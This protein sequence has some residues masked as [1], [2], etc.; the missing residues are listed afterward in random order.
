MDKKIIATGRNND[1][2]TFALFLSTRGADA[3]TA[4][5][6][7]RGELADRQD[8]FTRD[9]L[10]WAQLQSGDLEGARENIALALAEGTEDARLFYHAG[11]IAAAAQ[12]NL[13]ALAFSKK[14]EAI[15]QMLLPSERAA[16]D[17][18]VAAL[19]GSGS[20]ISSR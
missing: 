17:R 18:Q 8:V 3:A 20:T 10:A 1:P 11:A 5:E 6:L 19:T 12:E 13:S 14:A 4:L 15:S 7:A 16:L 9:A 2:R